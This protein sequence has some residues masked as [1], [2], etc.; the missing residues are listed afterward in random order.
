MKVWKSWMAPHY[1]T[2]NATDYNNVFGNVSANLMTEVQRRAGD[3]LTHETD[4]AGDQ[5]EGRETADAAAP[6]IGR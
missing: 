6:T 1:P 5:P 4:S 2:R 3:T